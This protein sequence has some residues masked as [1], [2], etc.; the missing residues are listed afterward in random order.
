M[1]E[2]TTCPSL[3]MPAGGWVCALLLVRRPRPVRSP[4]PVVPVAVPG[5]ACGRWSPAG[6]GL[7]RRD[8]LGQKAL[9][10]LDSRGETSGEIEALSRVLNEPE[11]CRHVYL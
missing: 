5:S 1:G 11:S 6:G 9:R 10:V 4:W 7:G 8:G 3:S 2:P